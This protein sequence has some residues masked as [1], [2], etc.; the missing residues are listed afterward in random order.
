MLGQLFENIRKI[1][2]HIIDRFSPDR[3]PAY[4]QEQ[5]ES[6]STDLPYEDFMCLER[7]YVVLHDGLGLVWELQPI[8]H[9]TLSKNELVESIDR[10]TKVIE[11]IS[12]E[13]IILQLIMDAE[14]SSEFSVP[15][16]YEKPNTVAQH[17]M[18]Q[19][20]NKLKGNSQNL[21]SSDTPTMKRKFY[22]ALKIPRQD[23]L[24]SNN[25]NKTDDVSFEVNEQIDLMENLVR[26][27][28]LYAS[29][30]EESLFNR[31][32]NT[33]DLR[34]LTRNEFL[35]CIRDILHSSDFKKNSP[36]T[37]FKEWNQ[38]VNISEQVSFQDIVRLPGF[39]EIGEKDTWE[40][41]SWR[42]QPSD[43]F[44]GKMAEL[45][46]IYYPM[47]VI[48][49]IRANIT[50]QNKNELE[51]KESRL[52]WAFSAK[53]VRQK[54]EVRDSLERIEKGEGLVGLSLHILLRNK[55]KSLVDMKR[56]DES[57]NL[58]N[59]LEGMLDIT[60][61]REKWAGAA[62]FD[63]CLPL[64]YHPASHIFTGREEIVLTRELSAY[65][66]VLG[67]FLGHNGKVQ[68]MQARSGESCW[69]SSR[70]GDLNPHIAVLGSSG[71]GKSFLTAN[72]LLSALASEPEMNV[73]V[74][75]IKTS[76]VMIAKTLAFKKDSYDVINPPNKFPNIFLGDIADPERLSLI[77]SIL[78]NAIIL[79]DPS[80]RITLEHETIIS[81]SIKSAY[82]HN[83]NLASEHHKKYADKNNTQELYYQVPKLDDIVFNFSEMCTKLN[84]SQ[85]YAKYLQNKLLSFCSG[86]LY[87]N[88]FNQDATSNNEGD[89]KQ[90][91]L[92]DLD[93]VL[94]NKI[95]KTLATQICISDILRMIKHKKNIG[96][97]SIFLIDEAGVL[98]EG[99]VENNELI[100]FI[101]NAWKTFRK[102]NTV[103][104]GITNSVDDY[105]E[106]LA[107]RA[108]W[109]ISPHKMIL[110][111]T[112]TDIEAARSI[113]PGENKPLFTGEMET[114]VR[115]LGKIDGRY[116]QGYFHSDDLPSGTF[117]YVP[118]GFDY[119]LSVSKKEELRTC[120]LVKNKKGSYW[121][122]IKALAE[123]S[124]LGFS[125]TRDGER[126][127]RAIN[128][129][130][131][132][133]I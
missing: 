77:V 115:S 2:T 21:D 30:F 20:I 57:S 8:F 100:L 15:G 14:P 44:I 37:H 16:Y 62:I 48:L 124:P 50:K 98:L 81:E 130:E 71:A 82:A 33:S 106:K 91:N 105:K 39:I 60:F 102:L 78:K 41:L 42:M 36:A 132:D 108:I 35:F 110:K 119:W 51:S 133:K 11:K 53:D 88:I 1:P 127:V 126:F 66:P 65:L 63:L 49:N 103:C 67:G 27:M 54:L 56:N 32:K 94:E 83:K 59:K 9:E 18:V 117:N 45:L 6:I 80:V 113:K 26:K 122:A 7:D 95:I 38:K 99:N 25:T 40:V 64:A 131:L 96:K 104:F 52:K 129:E 29:H 101:I 17:I 84:Y 128:N 68:L 75:D 107:C 93:G 43:V 125:E 120:E 61:V 112:S 55:N 22:L 87:G 86:G 3:I 116:S 13:D 92:Y 79:C 69:L 109:N 90:I 114:I 89:L 74:V 118:T 72:Y 121:E 111:M 23:K 19:R 73:Y 10:I 28:R 123:F 97:K 31:K 46:K 58:M 85:E 70:S 34:A 12:D 5:P 47:R 24:G 76:Y 4:M